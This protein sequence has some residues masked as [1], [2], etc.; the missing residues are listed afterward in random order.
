LA[1]NFGQLL[2]FIK[3]MTRLLA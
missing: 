3:G 1:L 2:L